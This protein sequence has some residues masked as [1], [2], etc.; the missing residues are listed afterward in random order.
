MGASYIFSKNYWDYL[1]GYDGLKLYGREE[2]YLSIKSWGLGDGCYL[3]KDCKIAHLYRLEAPQ[4]ITTE[5]V[6]DNIMVI[7]ETLLPNHLKSYIIQDMKSKYPNVLDRSYG[8]LEERRSEI[9][10]LRQYYISRGFDFTRFLSI[11]NEVKKL[12]NYD[13]DYK[14]WE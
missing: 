1:K 5:E 3:V 7:A 12:N 4:P 6:W 14:C 11:N 9:E 10:S 2:E 13:E 8:K